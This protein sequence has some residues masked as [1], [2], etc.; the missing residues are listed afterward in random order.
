[1]V[2]FWKNKKE[3]TKEKED[4]KTTKKAATGKEKKSKTKKS[5]SSSKATKKQVKEER[6]AVSK[7][8]KKESKKVEEKKEKEKSETKKQEKKKYGNAYR[9]LI[10]PLITEKASILGAENKYFFEV[11]RDANKIEVAKA[12]EE[13]YGIKPVKVNIVNMRGKKVRFGRILGK[14]KDWKKA[15]V[16][17]PEGKTIKIYEGV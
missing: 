7:K 16:T 4:G 1:M 6:K 3:E 15:I 14:R 17:L 13:V 5:T 10:R 9:V 11:A 12:I 2:L 8:A